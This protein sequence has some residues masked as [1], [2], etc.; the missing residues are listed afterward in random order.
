MSNHAYIHNKNKNQAQICA[1]DADQ[2]WVVEISQGNHTMVHG[3]Y[4]SLPSAQLIL[5]ALGFEPM[6]GVEND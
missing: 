2:V 5:S 1:Y 6:M 3:F 4:P